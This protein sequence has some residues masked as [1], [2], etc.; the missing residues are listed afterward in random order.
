MYIHVTCDQR[1]IPHLHL[2]PR[3]D[4]NLIQI[5]GKYIK[6]YSAIMLISNTHTKL[7]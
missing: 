2:Q 6:T 5:S 7:I 4:I 3:T 1:H